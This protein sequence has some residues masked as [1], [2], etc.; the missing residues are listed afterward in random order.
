MNTT[1]TPE[2]F[3]TEN[4]LIMTNVITAAFALFS[5]LMALSSC[6][7]NGLIDIFIKFCKKTNT[8]EDLSQDLSE[9]LSQDLSQD[10]LKAQ[11]RDLIKE[12]MKENVNIV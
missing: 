7:D 9:D 11:I 12:V 4:I 8:K 6:K 10:Q 1:Q 2:L 5:E 3:N